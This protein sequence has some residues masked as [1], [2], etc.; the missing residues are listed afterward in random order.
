MKNDILNG[1]MNC[2]EAGVEIEMKSMNIFM[3]RLPWREFC[4]EVYRN[5]NYLL[6]PRREGPRISG[7]S[8]S[9]LVSNAIFR[10]TSPRIFL[11]FC[12]KVGDYHEG[13]VTWADFPQK[14]VFPNVGI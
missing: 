6:D 14:L 11:K 10:K 2:G 13:E 12:M 3:F 1:L 7:L 5:G 8:V 4:A 9:L